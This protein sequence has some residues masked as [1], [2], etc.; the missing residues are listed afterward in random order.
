M[1]IAIIGSGIAGLSSAIRLVN[2]GHSVTIFERSKTFGGKIG[3]LKL[4]KFS[5]D[6]G[7][8]LLTL[9]HLIDEL[10]QDTWRKP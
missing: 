1:N 2:K 9:P 5:F 8:S 3:K 10:F 6:T 7:P 4:N